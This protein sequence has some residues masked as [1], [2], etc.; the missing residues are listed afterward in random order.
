MT[1]KQI[2]AAKNTLPSFRK[3]DSWSTAQKKLDRE[4]M[5]RE[6]I[7]SILIYGGKPRSEYNRRYMD[8][9]RKEL[10]EKRVEELIREQEEDFAKAKVVHG[11]YTDHEGCTYNSCKWAD[12]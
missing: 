8:S 9:Y 6:M 1:G 7:N 5:C 12:D 4:L 11:V 10:G 2:R 3:Y